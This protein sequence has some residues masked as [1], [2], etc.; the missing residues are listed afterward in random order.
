MFRVNAF[1]TTEKGSPTFSTHLYLNTAGTDFQS[2]FGMGNITVSG[3]AIDFNSKHIG[4]KIVRTSSGTASV[5][6]T[7]ADGT[8]ENASSAL[9][10]IATNGFGAIEFILKVNGTSS[11]DYYWRKD[12]GVLSAATNLTSNMPDG[13][14]TDLTSAVSNVAT[15]TNT[16][17]KVL[18]SSYQR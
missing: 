9:T 5:Y 18:S 14:G 12:D 10:T 8:T 16:T 7:Q 17:I 15:A 11:V 3:S 1:S 2:F 6:A 13:N 4:F